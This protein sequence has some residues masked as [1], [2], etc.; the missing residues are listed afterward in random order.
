[1]ASFATLDRTCKK[2][3]SVGADGEGLRNSLYSVPSQ[4]ILW[5]FLQNPSRAGPF[6]VA[7]FLTLVQDLGTACPFD[8]DNYRIPGE[9]T[10]PEPEI[11]MKARRKSGYLGQSEKL[12]GKS[13]NH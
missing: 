10:C 1:M 12:L 9:F 5:R 7:G 4:T 3:Q 13:C 6:G 11:W 8:P 2:R